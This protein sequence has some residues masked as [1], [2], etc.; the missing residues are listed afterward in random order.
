MFLKIFVYFNPFDENWRLVYYKKQ[1][2][3]IWYMSPGS[4]PPS[5]GCDVTHN[6][7]NLSPPCK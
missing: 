2:L 5:K 7:Y 4:G 1:T 6:F 3:N